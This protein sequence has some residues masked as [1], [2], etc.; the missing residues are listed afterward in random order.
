MNE[1]IAKIIEENIED[2][3]KKESLLFKI[4]KVDNTKTYEYIGNYYISLRPKEI[5]EKLSLKDN[6]PGDSFLCNFKDASE[7]IKNKIKECG[8]IKNINDALAFKMLAF[9]LDKAS[10]SNYSIKHKIGLCNLFLK[11]DSIIFINNYPQD[12]LKALNNDLNLLTKYL[13]KVSFW[14]N[15]LDVMQYVMKP[16]HEEY[17]QNLIAWLL[18]SKVCDNR[19]NRNKVIEKLDVLISDELFKKEMITKYNDISKD[20]HFEE[21]DVIESVDKFEIANYVVN[22]KKIQECASEN[23][24][25]ATVKVA[26]KDVTAYMQLEKINQSSCDILLKKY[27]IK[28]IDFENNEESIF[29]KDKDRSFWRKNIVILLY[30]KD[31]RN[32]FK[33]VFNY[34]LKNY[35]TSKGYNYY[36]EEKRKIMNNVISNILSITEEKE[37]KDGLTDIKN[38]NIKKIKI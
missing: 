4:T 19:G 10:K 25:Y 37:I 23:I 38:T 5:I 12:I 22:I 28:H 32:D 26:I 1:K 27:G 29:Y 18:D 24:S 3:L 17:K 11:N 9:M 33:G 35:I 36:G 6:V 34:I 8:W 14:K 30:G 16:L 15:N 20:M 2:F 7:D 13:K 21:I 31:L